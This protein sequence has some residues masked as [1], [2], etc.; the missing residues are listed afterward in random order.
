MSLSLNL[1][2]VIENNFV[3]GFANDRFAPK[4]VDHEWSQTIFCFLACLRLMI[5]A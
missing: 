5:S 3:P 4:A 2:L 1:S